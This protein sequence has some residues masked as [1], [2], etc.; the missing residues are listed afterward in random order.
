MDSASLR[1][2][3]LP[4]GFLQRLRAIVPADQFESVVASFGADKVTAFRINPLRTT[5]GPALAALHEAGI[6]VS[7]VAWCADAFL[8]AP[9]QRSALTHSPLVTSGDIYIQGLSSILASL[10]LDPRPGQQV[11]DLA[12]APGGKAT[13][14]AALMNNEGWLSVVEPGRQRMYRLAD[15]LK[16]AGV[17]IAHTYRMDGRQAGHKVP[18][19]FDR[20]LLDAPCSGESRFHVSRPESWQFWS[21]RK[22]REQSRKQRGLIL[23]AFRAL[24][25]GGQ[26][27]YA[28]C[29]F[30]PE[31][32]EA[33]VDHLLRKFSGRAH[34][35]PVDLPIENRHA[36]LTAFEN[37]AFDPQQKLAHRILPNAMHDGFFLTLI[38]KHR[39]P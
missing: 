22:I 13:H 20:V 18:G 5:S 33:I 39:D 35:L 11:L 12:A 29:S 38:G 16:R 26:M 9:G 3:E 34:L 15:N 24:K 1:E 2:T 37:N 27:L 4:P 17:T 30:A 31:E 10:I 14:L 28:T 19:R 7:P 6:A 23:S 36:G 8:V 32:N 25:P 21:L